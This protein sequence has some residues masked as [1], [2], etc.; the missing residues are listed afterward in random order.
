MDLKLEG[1]RV[2]ITASSGGIGLQ[3]ARLFLQE[4]ARIIINGR[5]KDK[6]N[7]AARQLQLEAGIDAVDMFLGNMCCQETIIS[8]RNY[9]KE[10][11]GA[12]DILIPNLGTGKALSK[13]R[14]DIVEWEYM[15]ENN[16]F[17]TVNLIH[18]F[19]PLLI[20]GNDTSIVM[21]SSI[22]AY[23]RANAPYAYAA[24]KNSIL[25]LNSYL[26]GDYAKKN[27][28]VNCVVPGNVFFHGGRWEELIKE[29]KNGVETY[30]NK[31]VPMRRFAKPEEIA[32][33]V[34]FLASE[35]SSFTTGAAV[36]IDG[37]QKRS[38]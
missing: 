13:E 33:T 17:S 11:W 5:T 16:L 34:I 2:L 30:I 20:K 28:R 14:L 18:T 21:I 9:I 1:K 6:L 35:K 7:E 29:D 12:L 37:G 36:V 23:E 27:I 8:C 26:A 22:V 19:E 15:M 38:I 32:N 10:K 31:N 4:G 3:I 25:T 24:A